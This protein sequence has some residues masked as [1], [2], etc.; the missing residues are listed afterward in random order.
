MGIVGSAKGLRR[1]ILPRAS[2]EKVLGAVE[3]SCLPV[4]GSDSD[5][6][7]DLPQRLQRY[8]NGERVDFP[9]RLDLSVATRFQQDVW[10]VTKNIPYGQTRSYGWVAVQLGKPKA[11]RAVGQALGRNPLPIII[12]CHRVVRSD[13][14][15]GGFSG[16]L[17]MKKLL[18]RLEKSYPGV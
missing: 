3:N 13:G 7:A 1:L 10:A 9:D 11:M 16:G 12:P 6:P 2:K 14:G 8:C 4:D 17:D 15:L 18:L 5:F